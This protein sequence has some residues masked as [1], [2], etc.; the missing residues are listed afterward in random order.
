MISVVIATCGSGEWE[1]LAWSRAYPSAIN[2]SL[3][4]HPAL[5]P[6]IVIEHLPDATLAQARNYGAAKATEPW[7]VFLDADDELS[8]Q[9]VAAMTSRLLSDTG[10]PFRLFAP[11]V[12]Y[13]TTDEHRTV[14]SEP[15]IP[16]THMTM[17][18]LNHCVIGT[19]VAAVVFNEVGGFRE[20]YYPW[21]DYELW[22]R[23]IRFGCTVQ[24]V[25]EC[26]Y[27]AHVAADSA[28]RALSRKD[29]VALSTKIHREHRRES[30]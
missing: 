3:L 10:D 12:S 19:A 30:R 20:G 27:M 14:W 26:V 17:P 2:A 8:P 6:Q 29:A 7:L 15:A 18:P 23:C 16:N 25:P 9:F 24:H 11:A 28:H 22:L 13:G 1:D 21:E 5:R 4:T